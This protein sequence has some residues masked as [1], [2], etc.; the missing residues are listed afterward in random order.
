M[1]LLRFLAV[2]LLAAAVPAHASDA[3]ERRAVL[4]AA[5]GLFDALAAKDPVRIMAHVLPDGRIGSHAVRDG[6][7]VVRTQSWS[8]WAQAIAAVPDRL[9]ERM[10][11]P[12]VRVRGSLATVWTEYTFWLN[13]AFSH[14]GVDLFDMAKVDGRWR[15]LN[16]T[17]TTETEHCPR[18]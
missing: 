1:K 10:H 9:E 14:C 8:E 16:F 17:F 11:D 6:R 18:R 2:L 3:D 15:V 12:H 13:G 7:V 4:G 5:Q